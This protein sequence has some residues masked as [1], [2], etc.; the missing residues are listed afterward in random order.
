MTT[1]QIPNNSHWKLY[2]LLTVLIGAGLLAGLVIWVQNSPG[3][4][5]GFG[6]GIMMGVY[7][8][9]CFGIPYCLISGVHVL[10]LECRKEKEHPAIIVFQILK[11]LFALTLAKWLLHV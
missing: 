10:Y 7:L 5:V 8:F 4:P 3:A 1:A 6:Y 9:G 2:A 11:I